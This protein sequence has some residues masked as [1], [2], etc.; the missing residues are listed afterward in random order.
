M[1]P[2][3]GMSL[4]IVWGCI[5]TQFFYFKYLMYRFFIFLDWVKLWSRGIIYVI[6]W[7]IS[8]AKEFTVMRIQICKFLTQHSYLARMQSSAA[9][10]LIK[11]STRAGLFTPV[12]M[13]RPYIL[14]VTF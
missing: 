5:L 14:P 10:P 11:S 7:V 3:T 9:A 6:D 1:T 4:G 13:E 12:S 2:V 8:G